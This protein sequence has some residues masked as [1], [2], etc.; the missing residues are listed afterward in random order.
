MSNLVKPL[1]DKWRE[2]RSQRQLA[3]ALH[4]TEQR[5]SNWK[6]GIEPMPNHHFAHL[7]ELVE[8]EENAKS[9]L[10]D[11]VREKRRDLVTAAHEMSERFKQALL[12]ANPRGG[13]F[14]AG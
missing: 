14:S 5:L 1:I 7:A 10:W 11:Y 8:G 3:Q 6:N 2:S 4:V 13:L 9:L 12:R